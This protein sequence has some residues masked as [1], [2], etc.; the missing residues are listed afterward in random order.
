MYEKRDEMRRKGENKRS[1]T[2]EN[3]KKPLKGNEIVPKNAWV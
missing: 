3:T 1:E 2:F